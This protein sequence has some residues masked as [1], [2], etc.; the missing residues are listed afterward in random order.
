MPI[1]FWPL[2][3]FTAGAL[4]LSAN[5][6]SAADLPPVAAISM[7]VQPLRAVRTPGSMLSLDVRCEGISGVGT[8]IP[9]TVSGAPVGT[10][11]E[12]L[13][14]SEQYALVSLIFPP[15]A[16]KGR[17]TLSVT[18]ASPALLVEQEVEIEIGE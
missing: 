15:T 11:I 10:N 8:Q 16:A 6:V 13:P 1:R 9:V 4:A 12:V 14:Q 7:Q 5:T 3:A 18:V 2:F 17:Y